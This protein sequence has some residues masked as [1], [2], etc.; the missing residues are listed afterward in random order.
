MTVETNSK[1][2]AIEWLEASIRK[3]ESFKA[4]VE[5]GSV[6]VSGGYFDDNYPVPMEEEL[7]ENNISLSIDF[8]E[9]K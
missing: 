9:K 5:D 6:I 4:F 1:D 3:L 2:K 8:I 7:T